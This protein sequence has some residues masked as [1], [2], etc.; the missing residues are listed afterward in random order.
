MRDRVSSAASARPSM[1]E[2]SDDLPACGVDDLAGRPW[3]DA[4]RSGSSEVVRDSGGVGDVPILDS[5]R[6]SRD[7]VESRRWLGYLVLVATRGTPG[8]K[9]GGGLTGAASPGDVMDPNGFRGITRKGN[10]EAVGLAH[11]LRVRRV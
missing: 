10:S 11:G 4:G 7:A 6:S 3:G 5:A 1:G 8:E 9:D 2:P